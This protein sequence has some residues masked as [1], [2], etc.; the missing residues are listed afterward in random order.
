M[1]RTLPFS[2]K[3]LSVALLVTVL[4][5][6]LLSLI[7]THAGTLAA[8]SVLLAVAN[9]PLMFVKAGDLAKLGMRRYEPIAGITVGGAGA[10]S[11]IPVPTQRRLLLARIYASA[12]G[13]VYGASVIDGIQFYVGT[14]LIGEIT[15]AEALSIAKINGLGT[16]VPSATVGLPIFMAEPWRAS[17][18]DEEAT[19][20]DLFGVPN[21]TIKARTKAGLTGVNVSVVHVYDDE[22]VTNAK[23][24]RV[25]NIIKNEPIYLGTL[26]TQADILSPQIPVDMPIQRILVIPAAGVTVSRVKVTVNDNQIV[27]DLSQAENINFLADYGLVAAAGNGEIYPVV[28]DAD[29]QLFDGLPVVRNLKLSITQSGAGAVKLLVQRRASAYV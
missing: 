7:Q 17:V 12:D 24:E 2:R 15:A 20:W 8:V 10:D 3:Q 25:L 28:F 11:T 1:N 6:F 26:G 5:A 27:H 14:R 19:G 21:M 4:F 23:G 29:Q 9:A 22:F 18:M 13:P 16:I